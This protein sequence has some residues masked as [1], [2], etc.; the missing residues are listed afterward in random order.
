MRVSDWITLN[1]AQPV[2]AHPEQTIGAVAGTLLSHARHR[3]LYVV[4]ADDR[5]LGVVRHRRLAQ[6]LLAEHLPGQTRH[7]IMERVSSGS[8]KDLMERDCVSAKAD[9]ELDN[10]LNRMLEYEV[11]DMPVVD[12]AGTVVGS[13]NLT[14]V[15]RAV[16]KGEL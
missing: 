3:D 10:V 13:I 7:Q 14:E 16:H 15:L 8:L 5:L 2:V 12:D 9:E 4:S 1:P 11:D 6:I